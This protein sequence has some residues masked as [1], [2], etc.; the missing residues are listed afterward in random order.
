MR[1]LLVAAGI[2]V[3]GDEASGFEVTL[4]EVAYAA[5]YMGF[6]LDAD[7]FVVLDADARYRFLLLQRVARA[8]SWSALGGDGI[9]DR[10]EI[11]PDEDWAV[12]LAERWDLSDAITDEMYT[13]FPVSYRFMFID[14][15]K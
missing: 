7:R 11:V 3:T 14:Q 5:G 2:R 10:D 9:P 12:R 13:M 15:N 8:G 6:P 1:K 4:E